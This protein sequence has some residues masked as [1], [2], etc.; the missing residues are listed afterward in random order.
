M[1]SSLLTSLGHIKRTFYFTAPFPTT[2]VRLDRL[3]GEEEI[4]FKVE[5]LGLDRSKRNSMVNPMR[6]G[7]VTTSKVAVV[8]MKQ[9][10][11]EISG[12]Q[13]LYPDPG[14]DNGLT[15]T[16]SFEPVNPGYRPAQTGKPFQAGDMST[17][18][19]KASELDCL[20]ECRAASGCKGWAFHWQPTW[21]DGGQSGDCR[22]K[23]S[24]SAGSVTETRAEFV[25]RW[26]GGQMVHIDRGSL[27]PGGHIYLH[28]HIH[29]DRAS[30]DPSYQGKISPDLTITHSLPSW[31]ADS[32]ERIQQ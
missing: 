2:K 28:T 3:D 31:T 12:T 29:K 4:V 5:F 20:A 6:G 10:D 11:L 9:S 8:R 24:L 32:E 15:G 27:C 17:V 22:L 25:A 13:N 14:S 23:S 18:T 1:C 26:K 16:N 19:G 30:D 7:Y 21:T